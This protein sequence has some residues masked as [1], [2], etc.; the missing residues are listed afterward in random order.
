MAGKQFTFGYSDIL[1]MTDVSMD[2]LFQ[3]VSRGE[4]DPN[5]IKSVVMWV[6]KY[7]SSSVR[8]NLIRSLIRDDLHVNSIG[9]GRK[10]RAAKKAGK[11]K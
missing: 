5:D 9:K 11:K 1:K 10:K 8:M 6:A 2:A 3:H 7:G 4:L